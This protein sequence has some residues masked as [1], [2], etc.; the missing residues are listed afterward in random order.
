MGDV[1]PAGIGQH[2]PRHPLGDHHVEPVAR[3][4]I[5]DEIPRPQHDGPHARR[6]VAFL[7]LAPD[8]AKRMLRPMRHVRPDHLRHVGAVDIDIAGQDHRSTRRF[9]RRDH[10]AGQPRNLGAP[11]AVGRVP[12]VD[13]HVDAHG[14]SRQVI[15]APEATHAPARRVKG[16]RGVAAHAARGA[17]DQDGL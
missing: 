13:D 6:A 10:R 11:L 8:T 3:G 4:G 2:A 12:G 17:K 7:H 5:V 15:A 1:G 14:R 9:R 16:Q